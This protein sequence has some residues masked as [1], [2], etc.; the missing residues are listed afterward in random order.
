[1]HESSQ[2]C[3][4]CS[5][6]SPT[7]GINSSTHG[8]RANFRPSAIGSHGSLSPVRSLKLQD[9]HNQGTLV[10][11]AF[12]CG[13][14]TLNPKHPNPS[15]EHKCICTHS[16]FTLRSAVQQQRPPNSISRSR[17]RSKSSRL[18]C[19]APGLKQHCWSKAACPAASTQRAPQ[20]MLT[21]LVQAASCSSGRGPSE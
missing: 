7:S 10:H 3:K 5:R 9:M 4:C 11:S 21:G 15:A 13:M 2:S 14:C 6:A 18:H 17:S 1:M 20:S 12:T 16:S 8:C 19:L